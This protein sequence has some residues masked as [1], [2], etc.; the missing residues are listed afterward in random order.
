MMSQTER[1]DRIFEQTSIEV[2]AQVRAIIQHEKTALAEGFYAVMLGD[3]D[4][5]PY[6]EAATVEQR[7]KPSMASWV[8]QLLC[9]E[10]SATLAHFITMQRHVGE[11]HAR[12]EIP[13]NLVL[14]GMQWLKQTINRHLQKSSLQRDEL[15]SAVLHVHHLFDI[16]FEEMSAAYVHSHD[17]GV[18]A[19]EAFKLFASGHNMAAERERQLGAVLDWESRLFR[20]SAIELPL[21][22]VVCL[23]AS[24]FGLWLNHKA[25]LVF[26]EK[27][28]LSAISDAIARIDEGLLPQL[29]SSQVTKLSLDDRRIL[30][31]SLQHEI[32]Q[33]KFLLADMFDRAND[34]EVGRDALTQLFNRRYLP[35]ILKREIELSRRKGLSFAVVMLDVDHF[36]KVN[37]SHGH[38]AGDLV[39]QQVATLMTNRLRSADFLFRYGGEEF[40]LLLTEVDE[41]NALK[42][43]EKLRSCIAEAVVIL[44]AEKTLNITA[45]LGVALSDG[46]PDYERIIQ[47][48]DAA[49]YE[50]KNTGRNRVVLA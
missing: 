36:K 49:L 28:E 43:A 16:A 8:E 38:D 42:V 1:L 46:H 9:S 3:P 47:R 17:K 21:R 19:D 34:L 15:V 32:E 23:R 35:A 40:L 50:A 44:P 12:A 20:E 31:R 22:G 2:R 13:V 14:R 29:R 33:I 48:A 41:E 24:A 5:A 27:R 18:R 7:L 25:S 4:S 10:D 6:L 26:D 37:D 30:M 45:S 11:V 39:L